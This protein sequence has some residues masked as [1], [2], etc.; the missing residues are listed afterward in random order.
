MEDEAME[1]RRADGSSLEKIL[2]SNENVKTYNGHPIIDQGL[3]HCNE[4][5]FNQKIHREPVVGRDGRMEKE[6]SKQSLGKWTRFVHS[7][8][9]AN[10]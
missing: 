4:A 6:G 7:I 8:Q 10:Q 5:I 2:T 1:A 3:L 9:N